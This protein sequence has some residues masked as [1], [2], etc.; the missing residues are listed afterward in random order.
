M[1]QNGSKWFRMY[2]AKDVVEYIEATSSGKLCS[3]H[4]FRLSTIPVTNRI[5]HELIQVENDKISHS[6][7]QLTALK[8]QI[9][10][11]EFGYCD[12]DNWR[13]FV[14]FSARLCPNFH[15]RPC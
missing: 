13:W 11:G 14:I 10:Y 12:I 7:V 4:V 2:F 6:H 9:Q 3:F 1:V 8:H 5:I 15:V